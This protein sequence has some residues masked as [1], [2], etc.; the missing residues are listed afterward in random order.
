MIVPAIV[1]FLLSRMFGLEA[2]LQRGWAIPM[3]TDIAFVV[4]VMALFGDRIPASLKILLLTLAIVDDLGAVLLI[5]FVFTDTIHM[6]ALGIAAVGVVTALIMRLLGVR[7]VPLYVAVGVIVW[8]AV[9]KS[10]VHPTVAGVLLG[11]MTPASPWIPT[12]RLA[13]ILQTTVSNLQT[14]GLTL[15]TRAFWPG[16]IRGP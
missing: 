4:G 2:A 3:A 15:D 6:A 5:A 11:L 12:D 13:E 9:L 7:P 16:R 14:A 10:G 8:L 1:Y